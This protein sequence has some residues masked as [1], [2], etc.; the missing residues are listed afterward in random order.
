LAQNKVFQGHPTAVF[1][2]REKKYLLVYRIYWG[3]RRGGGFLFTLLKKKYIYWY[4]N[5]DGLQ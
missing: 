4:I 2:Y 5:F 3:C 1:F